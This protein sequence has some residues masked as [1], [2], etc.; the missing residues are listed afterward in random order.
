MPLIGVTYMSHVHREPTLHG[1]SVNSKCGCWHI[2]LLKFKILFRA[3]ITENL[4]LTKTQECLPCRQT[5]G[6]G[7]C[8]PASCTSPASNVLCQLNEVPT[9]VAIHSRDVSKP[10]YS[11]LKP[12]GGKLG[13][14]IF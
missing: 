7:I 4:P 8:T 2:V 12:S 6:Q 11:A 13:T 1:F 9:T 5:E 3:W 14:G 10:P